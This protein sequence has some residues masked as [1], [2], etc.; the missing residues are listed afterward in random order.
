MVIL[1]FCSAII[2]Y[3]MKAL[4]FTNI[5]IASFPLYRFR[6]ILQLTIPT[7]LKL[8]TFLLLFVINVHYYSITSYSAFTQYPFF[9]ATLP[10]AF[11][12]FSTTILS[13]P[14]TSLSFIY[15]IIFYSVFLSNSLFSYGPHLFLFPTI[16]FRFGIAFCIWLTFQIQRV[17]LFNFSLFQVNLS[18]MLPTFQLHKL[19]FPP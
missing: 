7:L 3:F 2:I 16:R 4:Y 14:Y 18:E 12:L 15:L 9:F 1:Y 5:F 10:S 6:T 13:H 11:S 19:E 8:L 17:V